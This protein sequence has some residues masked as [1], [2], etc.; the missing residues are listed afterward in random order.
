MTLA[1][2]ST[3]HDFRS[4]C[5]ISRVLEVAGDKWTLLIVRDLL[6]HGRHTF[7]ALQASDEHIPPNILSVRLRR[8]MDW[9]LVI[10]EPYQERP[11]RYAYDLT[12]AGRALE[13]ILLQLM[14]WGHEHLGGGNFKPPEHQ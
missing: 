4:D 3:P 10:R 7:Q 8:L 12:D 1:P 13:P 11:T 5:S 9:G 14:A 6:W 2:A